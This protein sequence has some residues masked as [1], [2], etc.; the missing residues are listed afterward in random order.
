MWEY[1]QVILSLHPPSFQLS[2]FPTLFLAQARVESRS[3]AMPR[4]MLWTKFPSE[5]EHR[6]ESGGWGGNQR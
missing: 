6:H 1:T 2:G 3:V 5:T 4:L